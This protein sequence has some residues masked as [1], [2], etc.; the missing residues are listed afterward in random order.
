MPKSVINESKIFC[1]YC[2]NE[3]T[4]NEEL[5]LNYHLSCNNEFEKIKQ[6]IDFINWLR[7]HGI[8]SYN[9][10]DDLITF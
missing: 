7:L 2:K 9:T 8:E 3:L 10:P 1:K 5:N 6:N 4:E